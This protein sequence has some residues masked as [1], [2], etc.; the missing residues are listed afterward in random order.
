M[1]F[2]PIKK[3]IIEGDRDVR[4][5][6]APRTALAE[7][8]GVAMVCVRLLFGA[9]DNKVI[10]LTGVV[11]SPAGCPTTLPKS[12]LKTQGGCRLSRRRSDHDR[13]GGGYPL[14]NW[15]RLTRNCRRNFH[16]TIFCI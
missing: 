10:A 5:K 14:P 3:M 12:R 2:D 13:R 7:G 15:G 16:K 1:H 11:F 4:P 6:A 9:D 8:E